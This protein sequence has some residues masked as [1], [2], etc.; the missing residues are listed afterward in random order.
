MASILGQSLS[1][2]IV[3]YGNFSVDMKS[4]LSSL[5]DQLREEDRVVIIHEGSESE[6]EKI[7]HLASSYEITSDCF[8]LT[9]SKGLSSGR[10]LAIERCKTV[11]LAF[12]DD[13][14]VL[15]EGWRESFERGTLQYPDSAGFTGPICPIYGSGSRILPNEMEWIVSCESSGGEQDKIVRNAFGA[16]MT[17]NAKLARD[18]GIFFDPSFGAVGGTEGTALAGEEAI[19]SMKIHDASAKQIMWLHDFTVGHNVPRSRTNLSYVLHRS[20]KE[21]KTKAKIRKSK[22]IFGPKNS[23]LSKEISHLFRTVFIG[24]PIQIVRFPISPISS[25]WNTIGI[26]TMLFGTTLGFLLPNVIK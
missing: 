24:L 22:K 18:L 23:A 1:V 7:K 8:P 13:D 26:I 19:F 2:G 10:N 3:T 11:W 5:Q 17:I 9:G 20:I 14:A 6:F 21:G 16:N 4:C 15:L 12:V 25:F